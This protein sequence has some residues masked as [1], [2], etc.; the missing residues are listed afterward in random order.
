M[1]KRF[2]D[3]LL[4][5]FPSPWRF[6]RRWYWRHHWEQMSDEGR[7]IA[8]VFGVDYDTLIKRGLL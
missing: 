2:K 1:L 5:G 3:W 7:A 4:A 6:L 8:Y